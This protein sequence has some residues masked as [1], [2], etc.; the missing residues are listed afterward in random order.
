MK[1]I[2]RVFVFFFL[3]A[4]SIFARGQDFDADM[5]KSEIFFNQGKYFE[6]AKVSEQ[7][8]ATTRDSVGENDTSLYVYLV[9]WVGKCYYQ[10][11]SFETAEPLLKEVARIKKKTYGENHPDY[12]QA[13]NNLATLYIKIGLY[14]QAEPLMEKALRI[15]K[16][17]LSENNPS[18]GIRLKNLALIYQG[19][20]KY[21]QAE[22]LMKE[23]IRIDKDSLGEDHPDYGCDL[24]YLAELYTVM[25][26]YKQAVPLM[27]EAMRIAKES[28]DKYHSEYIIYLANMALL[29]QDLGWYGQAELLMKEA[30]RID[31]DSLG[32]NHPSYGIDLNNLASLY[33]AMGRY[34]QAESLMK[35]TIRIYKHSLGENHPSYGR[36]LNNLAELYMRIGRYEQVEPLLKEAVRIAKA[37]LDGNHTDYCMFLDNL[38]SFCFKMGRN[39]EAEALIKEVMRIAKERH[40][41][42]HPQYAVYL[43]RLALLNFKIGRNE[44]VESMLKEAIRIAKV[45][46]G[47]NNPDYGTYLNNLSAFYFQMG[48]YEQAEQLIKV[49][50]GILK[51]N[52]RDNIGFLSEQE[53]EQFFATIIYNF[54]AYQS[55]NTWNVKYNASTGEFAFNIELYRKGAQLRS[56][57]G[58][59]NSILESRDTMLL[60]DFNRLLLLRKQIEKLWSIDS[61]RRYDNPVNLEQQANELEKSL[62]KRSQDYRQ[63]KEELDYS[64]KDIQNQLKPDEAVIEFTSFD[65]YNKRWTDS[66]YYCALVLRPGYEYPKM[67][68]LCEEQALLDIREKAGHENT[69]GNID[70]LYALNRGTE[71]VGVDDD[72]IYQTN[73]L[74]RLVWQPIDS[75][76]KG[77]TTIWYSPSGLV[78][79]ISI[80][81]IAL[82]EKE[83]LCD[84]YQL[85]CLSSS[86][87]L[88]RKKE[89]KALFATGSKVALF[90]GINYEWHDNQ[91]QR[92]QESTGV[93]LIAMRS[94]WLPGDPT[95]GTDFSDLPGTMAEVNAIDGICRNH[96]VKDTLYTSNLATEASFKALS[97]KESPV[98]IHLATH[99]F[100]FDDPKKD[101]SSMQMVESGKQ[102]YK[103]SEDPL[104]RSGLIMAGGNRAWKGD[105]VP[106]G[107]ENGI[108]Q[109]KEV[110]NMDL[111]N[112]KL[113][114]LSACETGLGDVKGSEGVFGLQRSFKMAGVDYLLISLW[115]VPD[116]AT[117]KL[118]TMFYENLFNGQPIREAFKNAQ[119]QLRHLKKEYEDP[120]YWAAWVLVE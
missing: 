45:S 75:L 108:L 84:R 82:N 32:E 89:E 70:R 44:Q 85:N 101:Y 100:F 93:Q 38:A 18:Y 118:M 109:A 54:E 53:L 47:E 49:A 95:R 41:E 10:A 66:T 21:D 97:G 29:Y 106:E 23:A 25:G 4:A 60:R 110:S 27:K 7:W 34:E 68:F 5:R 62:S 16:I 12:G 112:T 33:L 72:S 92:V 2:V 77:A 24:Y 80:P 37:S 99:G 65:F 36:G 59:R 13:L 15:A 87:E 1:T 88:I 78:H 58:V 39:E 17:T 114:V 63:A 51:N 115:Q 81:A 76:L 35:E 104:L 28:H 8:L 64:W 14:V 30:I 55:F 98:I 107:M 90:G 69:Q 40:G 67:V 79:R 19:I 46:L 52:I 96:Q 56:T 6:A 20:G 91:P 94:A 61:A 74:Y 42:N 43:S 102:S 31:K 83:R 120:F 71:L 103:Y 117:Q 22:L 119:T 26:W 11:G 57:Q 105:T 73:A 86:R 9:S 113:V 116:E 48:L 50:F 3:L 111:R